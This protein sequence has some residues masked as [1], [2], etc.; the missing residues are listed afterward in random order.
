GRTPARGG[1]PF[2]WGGRRA[3]CTRASR[4]LPRFRVPARVGPDRPRGCGRTHVVRSGFGPSDCVQ[5]RRVG[6]LR[7]SPDGTRLIAPVSELKPDGKSYGTSLWEIDPSGSAEPRRLTR[8]AE[9]EAAPEFLP[10][11]SLLFVSKRPDPT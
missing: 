3:L 9:G 1:R 8:S 7:L 6:G 2:R 10:D 4:P 5:L 11:G